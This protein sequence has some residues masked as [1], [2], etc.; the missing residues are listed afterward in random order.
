MSSDDTQTFQMIAVR[1]Q[2]NMTHVTE[3]YDA[4]LW[5]PEVQPDEYRVGYVA[6]DQDDRAPTEEEKR[7]IT[8]DPIVV[9]AT[10]F[11]AD[12][13]LKKP[14]SWKL[15]FKANN[16]KLGYYRPEH[17][18]ASYVALGD[19]PVLLK[20]HPRVGESTTDDIDPHFRMVHKALL[21]YGEYP[22][23]PIWKDGESLWNIRGSAFFRWSGTQRDKPSGQAWLLSADALVG[24]LQNLT[25]TPGKEIEITGRA[26]EHTSITNNDDAEVTH[27]VN[28]QRTLSRSV[29]G[30]WQS[31]DSTE[32]GTKFGV[33]LQLVTKLKVPPVFE[34]ETSVKTSF[35]QSITRT[36]KRA[37]GGGT[38]TLEAATYG[39]RCVIKI[40]PRQTV[41]IDALLCNARYDVDYE[42]DLVLASGKPGAPPLTVKVKGTF[43]HDVDTRQSVWN[44]VNGSIESLTP[45][46]D[47]AV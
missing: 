25:V 4:H 33:E 40:P 16:G 43:A 1:P 27:E 42:G 31:E 19:V 37:V 30:T 15:L 46:G 20:S 41:K 32:I 13:V 5:K 23:N 22:N 45:T 38:T 9:R 21:T 2:Y 29:T 7:G 10:G 18:D 28:V 44:I 34:L 8:G 12:M 39:E 14:T 26:L 11:L 3:Y 24:R 36:M 35:E 47:G 17:T 6:V